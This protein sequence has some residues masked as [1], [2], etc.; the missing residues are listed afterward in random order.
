M[1]QGRRRLQPR[2]PAL[3]LDHPVALDRRADGLGR[4]AVRLLAH[5]HQPSPGQGPALAQQGDGDLG[6][7]VGGPALADPV[8]AR[9]DGQDRPLARRDQ[10]VG[11][12]LRVAADEQ[13]GRGNLVQLQR[14]RRLLD[15]VHA[16]QDLALHRPALAPQLARQGRAAHVD[17]QPPVRL[18]HLVPQGDPVP[19]P[20][21]VQGDQP[22]QARQVR[23]QRR[24][25]GRT[26]DGE[27][28][29]RDG[30]DQLGQ[31]PR[32]QDRLFGVRLGDVEDRETTMH[33]GS[34]AG[35]STR[36]SGKMARHSPPRGAVSGPASRRPGRP[37]GRRGPVAEARPLR[38]ATAAF[39][40]M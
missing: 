29:V 18:A 21:A 10:G 19:A 3:Q 14:P 20:V 39:T 24:A 2:Q 30:L 26:D 37:D 36:F 38:G 15:Q 27:G 4:V 8:R 6:V 25:G 17:H 23:E 12:F 34:L 5:D 22:L 33:G 1:R 31:R 35:F 32:R 11:G 16:R 7:A 13:P 28:G 40:V 9:P